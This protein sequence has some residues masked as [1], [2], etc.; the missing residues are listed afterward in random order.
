MEEMRTICSMVRSGELKAKQLKLEE[1]ENY[2]DR[3]YHT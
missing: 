3:W 1:L 2:M